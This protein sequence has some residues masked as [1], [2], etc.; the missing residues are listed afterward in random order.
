MSWEEWGKEEAENI[1]RIK[2]LRN[3]GHTRHC[4][5]RLVWGD[6]E[7]ECG[8]HGRSRE[9]R[10]NRILQAVKRHE[11]TIVMLKKWLEVKGR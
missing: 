5:C 3:D 8:K 11:K 6:G 9:E 7:C 4:A 1:E 10:V 2:E